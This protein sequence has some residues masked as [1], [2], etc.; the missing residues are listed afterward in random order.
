MDEESPLSENTTTPQDTRSHSDIASSKI[1]R[2]SHR[3]SRA[4]CKSCKT[5]RVKCDELK[6]QCANCKRRNIRCD[7][8]LPT[9]SLASQSSRALDHA[10]D[11][12]LSEIELTYHWVTT[13]SRSLSAWSSG[14]T[15]WQT[16]LEDVA[17]NHQHILHLMFSLTA[18]QLAY[19]R[20]S[21]SDEYIAT[22]DHH[23]ERAL[24]SVTHDLAN[25]S[26][27]NCDA[28]LIS[29]Q[30]I[31]F[32]G[33]ARGPQPGEYLAFGDHGRSDWLI[34]FR[35]IRTTME[36]IRKESF[37]KTHASATK[38]K[39]RQI[40]SLIEPDGYVLQLSELREHVAATS[41]TAES[42]GNLWAVDILKEC[43][44]SR[45]DGTDSEYHVVFAWLYKMPDIFLD[46][47]QQREPIPMIIFAHFIVLMHEMERFWYVT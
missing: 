28:V 43:Y 30:L 7:Y 17:L 47:L 32:V 13:T 9:E 36:S 10:E 25:I 44:D 20:P 31:C 15:V 4:G 45:Y 22:A 38:S 5:R 27:E 37:T 46:R 3:K 34:M 41:E 35:G 2:K 12:R 24:A 11:L 16:L 40:P 19:C 33:W 21:R 42:T 29:V 14:A 18:F 23:Y 39:S 26:T 6:P 8:T 1:T